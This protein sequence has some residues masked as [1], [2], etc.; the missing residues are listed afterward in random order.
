MNFCELDLR[1]KFEFHGVSVGRL[2]SYSCWNEQWFNKRT[3]IQL[4]HPIDHHV[5]E[6]IVIATF[7]LRPPGAVIPCQIRLAGK[8]GDQ[9][10]LEVFRQNVLIKL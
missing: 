9:V 2:S 6:D 8:N 7:T 10:T 4:M 5:I 3:L 1:Y